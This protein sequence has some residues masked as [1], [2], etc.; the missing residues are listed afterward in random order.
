M[1]RS[2]LR[3][4]SLKAFKVVHRMG[5]IPVFTGAALCSRGVDEGT[6]AS[7]LQVSS[8]GATD[9]VDT[10]LSFSSLFGRGGQRASTGTLAVQASG[11]LMAISV[12]TSAVGAW[13][14]PLQWRP[15]AGAEL[16]LTLGHRWRL[17]G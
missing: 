9:S 17:S 5:I 1:P 8:L 11:R 16:A 14:Q 12:S 3:V 4:S 15:P 7:W 6:A 13:L 10:Y 2:N